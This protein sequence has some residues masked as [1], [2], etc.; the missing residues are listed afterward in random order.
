MSLDVLHI[1]SPLRNDSGQPKRQA[2]PPT[3]T[4]ASNH[5][6]WE[7]DEGQGPHGEWA[8]EAITTS[9]GSY[10]TQYLTLFQGKPSELPFTPLS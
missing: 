4:T 8:N 5:V 6:T 9:D 1:Y 2:E 7:E 10:T 3:H